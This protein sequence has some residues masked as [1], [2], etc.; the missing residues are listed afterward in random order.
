MSKR[1]L[2]DSKSNYFSPAKKQR[3]SITYENGSKSNN[4]QSSSKQKDDIW[5]EDFQEEDLQ[6]IDLVA[7]QALSQVGFFL[8]YVTRSEFKNL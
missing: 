4:R 2:K 6:N 3:L 5:G 7:S 8:F 1:N